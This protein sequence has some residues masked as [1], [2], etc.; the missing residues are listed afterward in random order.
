MGIQSSKPMGTCSSKIIYDRFTTLPEIQHQL[1]L[2]GLESCDLIIG[3]DYTKSNLETGRNSFG[4]RS[5]HTISTVQNPYQYTIDIICRT[6]ESFDDDH[7]IPVFGFGDLNSRNETVFPLKNTN[8]FYCYGLPDV[9]TQYQ[10]ITPTLTLSG[11]TTFSPL[12]KTAVNIV[13]QT[14][15]YHILLIITDG[16]VSNPDFDAETIIEASNYGLSIVCIGVGDGPFD[17]MHTFDD[18][19]HSRKFDNF[20]FVE[21]NKLN[22]ENIDIAFAVS[23]LQ[24]IPDQYKYIKDNGLLKSYPRTNTNEYIKLLPN[25][26]STNS[27]FDENP[28]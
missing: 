13:K 1:R 14:G 27:N 28:K 7:L 3:I 19:L 10:L 4:G 24:E 15:R 6:L 12:I 21:L 16:A 8:S 22:R 25:Q 11:P 5:L 26:Q 18:K 2:N 17:T 20:Q 9:L 23:A